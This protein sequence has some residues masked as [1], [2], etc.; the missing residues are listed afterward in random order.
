MGE[1]VAFPGHR[2]HRCDRADC[3]WCG[4]GWLY[5][6]VCE[7]ASTSRAPSSLTSEC[8]GS[9]LSAAVLDDVRYGRADW[10]RRDG[11]VRLR[12]DSAE[13]LE[14]ASDLLDA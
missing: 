7:G 2:W 5:C 13:M 9:L 14:V 3:P 8:C 12:C 1:V 10:R 11:W 4:A 6:E